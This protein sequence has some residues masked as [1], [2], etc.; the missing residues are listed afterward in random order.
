M[1]VMILTS[2]IFQTLL[3]QWFLAAEPNDEVDEINLEKYKADYHFH[4]RDFETS[5]KHFKKCF[6]K[7]LCIC[8]R[9]T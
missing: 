7:L 5:L 8:V 3:L 4:Q 1:V 6:G 9:V 2:N